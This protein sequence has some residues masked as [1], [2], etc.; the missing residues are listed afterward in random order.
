MKLVANITREESLLRL[1]ATGFFVFSISLARA[2]D[3]TDITKLGGD[4]TSTLPRFGAIQVAAPNVTD[5]ARRQYQASGFGTFHSVF[6]PSEGLGPSFVNRSCNGCHVNN[7][8]GPARFSK[9]GNLGS[10]MVVKGSVRGRNPDGSPRPIPGIGEQLQEHL[11]NGKKTT[12]ISLRWIPVPGRYPDGKKFTLRRPELSVSLDERSTRGML[13]S[14][15]MTPALIG[16]GLLD[17]L[18]DE[19]IL[20]RADPSD[21]D[22]DGISGKPQYVIDAR[23]K[24]KRLGKFGFR[25]SHTTVE[26]QSAAAAFFDMG[27][28]NG[29]FSDATNSSELSDDSLDRLTVYLQLAGVPPARDQASSTVIAGRNRFMALGCESCHRMTMTTGDVAGAPELSNQTF[30]PFTDLL[31]HDMGPGL[32]DKRPEFEATGREWRTSPLW[33]VG[34]SEQLSSVRPLYL[35]D[36]RARNVEEAILWHGGEAESAKRGFMSLSEQE[37]AELIAFLRSL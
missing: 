36:G 10:T 28:T 19:A 8:R 4:L 26:E 25:A 6:L 34:F 18:S 23:T 2:Q 33:G 14:L 30:H 37:R 17:A 32:A 12:S 20:E 21:V 15:R 1:I 3:T 27:I 22:G 29:L 16:M 31:L 5:L 24:T 9:T 35:H 11:I 7:G 13:F